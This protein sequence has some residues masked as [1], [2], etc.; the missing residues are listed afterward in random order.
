M[1]ANRSVSS[2]PSRSG[3]IFKLGTKYSEA[4]GATVLD[5][6]AKSRVLVMGSYGIGLERNMAAVVETHHDD[7]GIV[8]PVSVAPYEVVVTVV[9]P[10]TTS[11]DGRRVELLHTTLLAV[12][13]M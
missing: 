13:S 7:K 12:E 6:K 9:K 5:E 10:W 11:H 3:H 8:W 2:G 1:R 4:L